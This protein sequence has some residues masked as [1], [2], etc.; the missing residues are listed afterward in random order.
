MPYQNINQYN[1]NKLFLQPVREVIDISLASDEKDYDSEIIFSQNIIGYN[2]GKILPINIEIFDSGTT[3]ENILISKNYWNQELPISATTFSLCDIGLTGIDNGLTDGISGYT[4]EINNSLYTN[5]NDKFNRYKYDQRM[6]FHKITGYTTPDNRIFND[7]SYTYSAI[8]A[9]DNNSVG[10]YLKLDGGFYQGFYKLFGHDYEVFPERV[11][12]GWSTEFL[13]R[14][15]FNSPSNVG[16][17]VR[18]SGNSGIFFYLGARSENKFYH[19]ATGI[20]FPSYTR[21]TSGLTY[22]ETCECSGSTSGKTC[23]HVY[24]VSGSSNPYYNEK[25]PLYDSLSNGVAIRLSGNT[26]NPKLCVRYFNLTGSCN[27]DNIYQTGTTFNE[28]C[29]TKGIFEKLKNTNYI[30]SENWV[31]INVVFKRYKYFDDCDL[32]YYGGLDKIKETKFLDSL[33]GK[34][35]LLIEP[36]ITQE[37]IEAE[38]V[39]IYQLNKKWIVDKD[40]RL[41]SLKIFIN[42]YPFMLLENFEEIIPRPLNANKNIQLSVPYNISIGG[43]TQGLHDNLIF[44]GSGMGYQQDPELLPTE[45]LNQTSFSG[46]TTN[47][48]LE[49]Y[50]GGSFI[51]DISA[52]RMYTK[53]LNAAEIRHN[54]KI[55]KNKY[56]LVNLFNPDC[57]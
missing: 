26:G 41:G 4:I 53:P 38:K 44:S 13:L 52:F 7:N 49:K 35:V 37:Q 21:V 12:L 14:Y 39:E 46:I 18:Y 31:Q 24:P 23:D 22:L 19:P 11:N 2:D 20:P 27:E 42:G 6:K 57:F 47:I 5:Q 17:N 50:F 16:L 43:G 1:F 10:N 9:N 33:D 54:F 56:S 28:I 40:N 15:R 29:S 55:L 3:T 25:N 32:K 8:L 30:Q 45:I 34:S 36:P 51:G 48:F